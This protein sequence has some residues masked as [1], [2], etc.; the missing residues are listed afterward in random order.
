MR[1]GLREIRL[2]VAAFEERSFTAAAHRENMTQSGVSQRIR[3]I[4]DRLGVRLFVRRGVAVAPTPAGEAYY[5]GCLE[6]IRT[7]ERT[8][9]VVRG[10]SGS[11]HGELVIGL[12]PTMTRGA[13][14]P[15][16]RAFV[17][18]HPNVSLR[19]VEGYSAELVSQI[20]SSE[21][22]FAIVPASDHGAGIRSGFFA[23]TPE[24]VV[25]SP[26]RGLPHLRPV[27]LVD[28]GPLRLI[29]PSGR[30]T[31][32]PRIEAYLASAG[33]PIERR[34]EM[35]S[36]FGTLDYV[37]MTDWVAILPGLMLVE[38]LDG[39]R[40]HVSAIL[41]P[42]MILDLVIIEPARRPLDEAAHAFLEALRESVAHLNATLTRR[43]AHKTAARHRRSRDA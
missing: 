6:M 23:S 36:M 33:V 2:F 24:L 41:E 30:N 26:S 21:L 34:L 1:P 15:A 31:R 25:S 37:A 42:E 10:H 43:L 38:D 18:R 27:R 4:E 5:Q 28:H 22:A 8:E 16:L 3:Q 29:L 12:M 17:A 20:R 32:G 39:A 11:L 19:I 7:Q 13:L 40:L 14:A 9:R 35:D